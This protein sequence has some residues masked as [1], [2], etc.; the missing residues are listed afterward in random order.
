MRRSTVCSSVLEL[1]LETTSP[2]V[3][4][5]IIVMHVCDPPFQDGGGGGGTIVTCKKCPKNQENRR[6]C[7]SK[8]PLSDSP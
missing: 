8:L 7:A 4:I 3:I 2:T 1:E 5:I 6:F